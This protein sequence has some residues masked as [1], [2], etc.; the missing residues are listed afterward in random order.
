MVADTTD[1][2][3]K[4]PNTVHNETE[5]ALAAREFEALFGA[6]N[7]WTQRAA[8]GDCAAL[9]NQGAQIDQLAF[10]EALDDETDQSE[11]I[12]IENEMD[13]EKWNKIMFLYFKFE[14]DN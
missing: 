9:L 12:W 4:P 13:I 11:S 8:Q 6:N 10:D 5:L 14:S 7:A 1:V 2:E 3:I